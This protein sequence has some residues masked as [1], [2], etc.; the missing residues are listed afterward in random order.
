MRDLISHPPDASGRPIR[1]YDH[2]SDT[3]CRAATLLA[4]L[5]PHL[6]LSISAEDVARAAF[7]V[8]C[9]HDFGKAKEQFQKYI[10]GGKGKEKDHAAISSV[11]TFIVASHVFDQKPQPTRLL[12]FVCAYAVNR[13]HGLLCNPEEAFD[14]SNIEYQIAIAEN[15]I[16]ERV[17]GFEFRCDPL[18]L[19][20][21][22]SDYRE[23]FESVTAGQIAECFQKFG[24]LL[25]QKSDEK[26]AAESWL[27]DLYF[28]LLLVVSSLTEADVACV[29]GAPEPRSS[30]RFEPD[31]VRKYAF[32]QPSA[33]DTFQ[34]LRKRAWEE[35]QRSIQKPYT[36]ALRLTLPT[37]LGKTLMGLYLSTSIQDK[38]SS[39]PVIYALPYLS[40]IEQA[41]DVAR[42]V[43][44][45][46]QND[47]SVIQHHSLSFPE[48]REEDTPNF[49]RARF[50]LED[51]D[52]DLVVTT[53]D[54]LFY[55]FLSND[56]GFIRRFFRLPGAVL[57]LDEVQTIP[58]R[59]IP[60]VDTLLQRLREKLG[61]RLI[62]MTA[63]HPPFLKATKSLVRD[64]SDYFRPLQ[65]TRLRLMLEPIPF[66]E[67]LQQVSDW[68]YE[69]KG[70]KVVI[71]ANTIRSARELF[72]R[73]RQLKEKDEK[74]EELRL[75]HLSG[76]V[77]PVERL[78]RIKAIRERIQSEPE[79]W[80]CVV[81][82][83]C[84]EAGVD[85]D[86]D[87]AVRDF[88]PWDSLLQICGRVNRFGRK[89]CADVWVYRWVDDGSDRG[90]EFHSYIY[91]SIFTTATSNVLSGCETVE[92]E[93][94]W[95]IQ[96]R[97][98][99][100]LEERLST[101]ASDAI[102]RSALAWR[103]DELDFQEL[104]R[105]QEQVWKI[106]VFCVA[107]DTAERL[108]EIAI[109][110]WSSKNS[111]GALKLLRELCDAAELFRPLGEFLRIEPCR[112]KQYTRGLDEEIEHR[113][114]FS[115]GR[116][117]R[118][119]FQAYTISVPIRRLDELVVDYITEGFP[120]LPRNVYQA[121]DVREHEI[122][123]PLP[124]WII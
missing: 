98:V 15:N 34:N 7:I 18:D 91:D 99:R 120:Y 38:T 45:D 26:D 12:P 63:S 57:L 17:W 122:E 68:L 72:V 16:D 117:L 13:H 83:Q 69:R 66:G 49:E 10:W 79:A 25:R 32:N 82:T 42:Q 76:S 54:Q 84:V 20:I 47:I 105:G 90:R 9:T 48:Q 92:E 29:I 77:V 14:E 103:F 93:Q 43:F 11:F 97:Y 108:K 61:V 124:H 80:I 106:S 28:T 58:A 5:E 107:D 118:P 53:F 46:D 71:V 119:M 89:P 27:V 110:L 21:R 1:L 30:A 31:Q 123:S 37:G 111:K 74:F 22:F 78:R 24:R 40:V 114:K 44:S 33:S 121:L 86:M 113:L 59:L 88:A 65:R 36:Q 109:E 96:Q 101:E 60:A 112:M 104:F 81:S 3:G 73:L 85:L 102:L 4:R 8:G 41:T 100:E 95:E 70:K 62:Y 19:T 39:K 6:N 56:R 116:L 35:I 75:F 87:E 64:E 52:A 67:Y 94:Y 51:W 115:L 2:L 50:A 23:K 55:S